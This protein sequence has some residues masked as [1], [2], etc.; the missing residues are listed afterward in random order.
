[1]KDKKIFNSDEVIDVEFVSEVKKHDEKFDEIDGNAQLV[2]EI[3]YQEDTKYYN[4]KRF[5]DN[6]ISYKN[7]KFKKPSLIKFLIFLPFLLIFLFLT[8]F[9]GLIMFVIFLPKI[10]LTIRK[11]KTSGLKM[12]YDLI[13]IVLKQFKAK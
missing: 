12:N 4:F 10:F 13:K 7:I 11:G 8:L 6:F 5:D 3:Q 2:Q 1:L 9:I